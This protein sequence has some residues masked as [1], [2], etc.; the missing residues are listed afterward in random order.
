L[1][2]GVLTPPAVADGI[3]FA[4]TI[5]APSQHD[6]AKEDFFGGA[7][8]GSMP[9]QLVAVDVA[10][11]EVVWDTEVPGDPLGGAL[12][13]GDLVFT[14]TMQGD[15]LAVDRASGDV[16]H[17]LRAPGGINGWPAATDDT[18]VWPVGM[19]EPAALVAYRAAR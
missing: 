8:L 2:G 17:T 16:V 14:A 13:M 5:N 19:A 10:R 7:P 18:I 12:V 11:G 3:V 4:P 6:P 1:F 9:G 15:I